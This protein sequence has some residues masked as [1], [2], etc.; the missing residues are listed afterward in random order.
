MKVHTNLICFL[1]KIMVIKRI[2]NK[3]HSVCQAYSIR[4]LRECSTTNRKMTPKNLSKSME[5]VL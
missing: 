5:R 2:K 3:M 4:L 1:N